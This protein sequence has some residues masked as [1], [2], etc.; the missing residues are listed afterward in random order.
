MTDPYWLP[1]AIMQ[2]MGA[3]L[4][5]YVGIYVLAVQRHINRTGER[6]IEIEHATKDKSSTFDSNLESVFDASLVRIQKHFEVLVIL[7]STTIIANSL[8]LDSLSTQLL[9]PHYCSVLGYIAFILFLMAV[10]YICMYSVGI[11]RW[12]QVYGGLKKYKIL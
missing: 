9:M 6:H 10:I 2:T 12:F 1:S 11:T 4:G 8:W 3:M 5:I 7:C